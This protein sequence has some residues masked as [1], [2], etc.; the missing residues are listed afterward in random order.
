MMETVTQLI[1]DTELVHVT[2]TSSSIGMEKL[3]FQTLMHRLR[4]A[5]LNIPSNKTKWK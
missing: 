3:E 2:Q 5:E 1:I 4:T